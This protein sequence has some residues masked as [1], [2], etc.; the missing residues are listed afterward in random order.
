MGP[1]SHGHYAPQHFL[2][3]ELPLEK[4]FN[5]DYLF[6]DARPH[7]DYVKNHIPGAISLNFENWDSCLIAFLEAWSPERPV[8]VYCGGQA[9]GLSKQVAIRLLTDLPDAQIFVLK[10]GFPAWQAHQAQPRPSS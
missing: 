10:H 7:A 8:V 9:C 4:E 1:S 6:V 2:I 5:S 3:K